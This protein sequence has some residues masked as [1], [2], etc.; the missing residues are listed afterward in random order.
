MFSLR[1]VSKSFSTSAGTALSA[2]DNVDLDVQAGEFISLVG[3][4]GCGKTTLLDLIAGFTHPTSGAILKNGASIDGPGPDRTMMFQDYALFPWLTVRANI[5][6]GLAAKRLSKPERESRVDHFI[7]LV[8]LS[9][10]AD[11]YPAQLSGG[12]R[13]RVSIARALAPEPDAV[14]MDEPF[15]A[16]DSLTRD[17]LQEELLRIWSRAKTTFVLITHNIEEAIYLSD[18]V[19][20][21]SNRPGR[22]RAVL[23]VPLPRPRDP[24]IRIRH[25][26]FLDLKQQVSELLGDRPVA[27]GLEAA[28]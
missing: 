5:A 10:F 4:S 26:V 19:V 7:A 17:K 9:G 21:I 18:R 14:L 6:F 23:P 11:A 15:A 20:V 16:L 13:Q 3:P 1:H 8:G 24:Q 12:M 25:P 27:S 22:I 28:H 2:L